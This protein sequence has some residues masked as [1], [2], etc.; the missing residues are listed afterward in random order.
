ME[1]LGAFKV[2]EHLRVAA[3]A[4]CS[5]DALICL[6]PMPDVVFQEWQKSSKPI[7]RA[8]SRAQVLEILEAQLRTGDVVLLKGSRKGQLDLLVQPLLKMG[9]QLAL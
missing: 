7:W 2:Q 3:Q 8:A 6:E 4:V 5:L 1:E 9:E